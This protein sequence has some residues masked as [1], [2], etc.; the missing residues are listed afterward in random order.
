MCRYGVKELHARLVLPGAC[1][2]ILLDLSQ[3]EVW[4]LSYFCYG[5]SRKSLIEC[6][7]LA[8]SRFCGM[9]YLSWILGPFVFH[10][11]FV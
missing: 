2:S 8:V 5:L 9:E 4:G 7:V 1:Y 10:A 3:L 6:Q 11:L